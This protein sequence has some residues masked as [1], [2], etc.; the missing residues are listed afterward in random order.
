MRKLIKNT[1]IAFIILV[2]L[3]GCTKVVETSP[4]IEAT[5]IEEIEAYQAAVDQYLE[6][7]KFNGSVLVSKGNDIYVSKGY[8]LADKE[9]NIPNESDTI[10]MIG[11]LTKSFTAIAILQLYEAGEL[12]LHDTIDKYFPNEYG[13][14]IH[15]LLTHTSGLDRDPNLDIPNFNGVINKDVIYQGVQMMKDEPLKA[16]PGESF[17][18]SNTGYVILG[19]IIEAVSGL[20]Y[21]DYI[22]KHIADPL[23]MKDTGYNIDNRP[24]ANKAKKIDSSPETPYPHLIFSGGGIH[25][26]VEDL[27]KYDRAIRNN[28]LISQESKELML[29]PFKGGHGYGWKVKGSNEYWHDGK[30]DI[31]LAYFSAN[32]D[33]DTTVIIL[34]NSVFTPIHKIE[35]NLKLMLNN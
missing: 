8:G 30:L 18:Y 33:S 34:S 15:H 23:E 26:T 4:D 22:K 21:S 2:L 7:E 14:T 16:N 20:S 25:S 6:K 24:I 3:M 5:N 31:F 13:I 1:L 17:I 12:D 27:Y 32:T 11:S 9:K 10:F 19:G 35:A 28:T 29:T